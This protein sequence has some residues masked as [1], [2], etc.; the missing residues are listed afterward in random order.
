MDVRCG[1]GYLGELNHVHWVRDENG[2]PEAWQRK[3]SEDGEILV[4]VVLKGGK[5]PR[6]KARTAGHT[7]RYEPRRDASSSACDD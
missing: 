7:I 3:V 4:S 5:D 6:A 1:V 2:V